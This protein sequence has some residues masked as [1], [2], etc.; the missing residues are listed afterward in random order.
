MQ[1]QSGRLAQTQCRLKWGE[2]PRAVMACLL[3]VEAQKAI[4]EKDEP[5]MSRWQAQVRLCHTHYPA[6]SEL[7]GFLQEACLTGIQ[8]SDA[9]SGATSDR[10]RA[11]SSVDPEKAFVGPCVVGLRLTGQIEQAR[12]QPPVLS[13]VHERCSQFFDHRQYHV[14][15]RSCLNAWG[16]I[17][18]SATTVS[19][20]LKLCR[21]TGSNTNSA[22][23]ASCLVGLALAASIEKPQ[24]TAALDQFRRCGK[25]EA[26]VR[27]RHD[28]RPFLGC[29]VGASLRALRSEKDSAA[30]L[31]L[32][33]RELFRV[34][35]R[36]RGGPGRQACSLA[37]RD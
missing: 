26:E 32:A 12:V 6:H 16:L 28:E 33:C 30:T 29:L 17:G 34:D 2:V 5:A 24:A 13:Q 31:E 20:Q 7:D 14:G 23:Q 10:T 8:L 15:Y 4:K 21:E 27:V 9:I 22:E 18:G 37:L 3:G 35:R 25:D 19:D 36:G 11:C 1:T